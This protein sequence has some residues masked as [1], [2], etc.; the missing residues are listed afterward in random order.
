MRVVLFL[1]RHYVYYFCT[2][3]LPFQSSCLH[4]TLVII[5]VSHCF[6]YL[7]V[8][9]NFDVIVRSLAIDIQTFCDARSHSETKSFVCVV[10][11]IKCV[12]LFRPMRGNIPCNLGTQ[13]TRKR[14][15][16]ASAHH[17]LKLRKYVR[18]Y[19]DTYARSVRSDARA[20]RAST[21]RVNF[22]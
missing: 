4:K 19:V 8:D 12:A 10:C 7:F 5:C 14:Q 1:H 17:V 9:D 18:T 13:R 3:L 6:F 20:A 16:N 22:L 11:N 15:Q 2:S 21:G